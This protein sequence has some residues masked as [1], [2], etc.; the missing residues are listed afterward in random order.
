MKFNFLLAM[1]M[2][3]SASTVGA[4][5]FPEKPI[6]VIVPFPAGSSSDLIPRMLAPLVSS[7]LG[8]PVIIENRAGANGSLGA[9]SVARATADGYTILLATTGVMAINQ[10][11]YPKL[12]Y[13][14]ERDFAPVINLASTPNVV[15]VRPG[16]P[17]SSLKE[18]AALAKSKP[19]QISY[20]SAGSGSTSHIC[21][22]S[23]KQAAKVEVTHVP[24]KGPAPAVLDLLGGR[25]SMMCDNLSNVLQYVNNGKLKAIALTASKRSPAAKDVPTSTEQGFPD[26]QAG[27]W[28]GLVAPARTPVEIVDRLNGEF[29]RALRDPAVVTRLEGMG[30]SIIADQPQAFKAAIAEDASRMKKVVATA[31]IEAD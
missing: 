19:G 15:V 25:I 26:V 1:V 12:A 23:F 27:I 9:S 29:A 7:S 4:A 31:G 20:G 2:A 6:T 11:I 22:E 28:Y 8:V 3:A 10:W 17:A 14:P 24:Y 30:L 18:L 5:A 21:G 16:V 13:V